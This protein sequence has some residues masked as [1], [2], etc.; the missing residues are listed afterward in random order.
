MPAAL[1]HRSMKNAWDMAGKIPAYENDAPS[2]SSLFTFTVTGQQDL[3]TEEEKAALD[4]GNTKALLP[5]PKEENREEVRDLSYFLAHLPEEA[6]PWMDAQ[7]SWSYDHPGAL[8]TPAKLTATAAVHLREL[9]EYRAGEEEP[10]PSA[11]LA[12]DGEDALDAD[13][14]APPLFMA[15]EET[16]YEGTSFGTLMH[17]AMEMIDF[18]AVPAE[19]EAIENALRRLVEKGV[20]TEEEGKILL[21][22]RRKPAPLSALLAF[23][24]GPLAEKMKTA[25]LI[26]K[27][28]PFSIL[29]PARSFYPDCE[30]GENIFLQGVMDCLLEYEKDFIIIDYKTDRTMTEEELK[31]HYKIQL[32]VYGEAAEKLL[33]KPVSHLYLW[34]FTY[35]KAI[36]VEKM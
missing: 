30:E 25:S 28:M 10:L 35:G 20:F 23:A 1:R 17:K 11:I 7:L 33:G 21:S 12:D 8:D 32:Q 19:P 15:G 29:L 4:E 24:R 9:A 18:T 27:E 16:K 2:D 14:A 3:L 13:Y 22:S 31:E 36:E 5:S 26:R 34:S 6:P